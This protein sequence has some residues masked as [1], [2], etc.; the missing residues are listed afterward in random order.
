LFEHSFFT[1]YLDIAIEFSTKNMHRNNK[2]CHVT[3]FASVWHVKL[4]ST[5]FLTFPLIIRSIT[6][7]QHSTVITLLQEGYTYSKIQTKTGLE[8]ATISRV[9]AEAL[10][11]KENNPA[12]H[13]SKLTT[14]DKQSIIHQI[15]TGK[16]DNLL[17]L[18]ILS[19]L[20][21]FILKQSGMY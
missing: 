1:K 11:D 17:I 9:K 21:L 13:P 15:S 7:A 16:L 12:G 14:Y 18:L 5:I 20:N 4:G 3:L 8:K 10:A 6:S 19:F 2:Q